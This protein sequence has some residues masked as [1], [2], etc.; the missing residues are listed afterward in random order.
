M[1]ERKAA[2]YILKLKSGETFDV[3]EETNLY[4]VCKGTQFKK[5]SR[6][7]ERVTRRKARKCSTTMEQNC[8][9]H[10][11]TQHTESVPVFISS[12]ASGFH[13]PL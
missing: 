9:D 6:Q 13:L 2:Q 7:I 5:T 8:A 10:S 12:A 4:W 3:I 1:A 11:P